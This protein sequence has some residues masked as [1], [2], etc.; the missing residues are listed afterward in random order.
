MLNVEELRSI[1]DFMCRC[2]DRNGF[3]GIDELE[4]TLFMLLES[5]IH[6]AKEKVDA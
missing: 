2:R 1:Y 3:L 6:H 5:L 4:E